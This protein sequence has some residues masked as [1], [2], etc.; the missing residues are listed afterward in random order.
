MN[1]Y[2]SASKNTLYFSLFSPLHM[3][4]SHSLCNT[5]AFDCFLK[6]SPGASAHL[7]L[8][9]KYITVNKKRHNCTDLYVMAFH[10]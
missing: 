6:L 8:C 10:Y 1:P 9:C 4:F 5:A 7:Y 2:T 3:P